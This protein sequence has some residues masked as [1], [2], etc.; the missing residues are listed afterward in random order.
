M[1][2]VNEEIKK[3]LSYCIQNDIKD[4]RITGI[5]T[6]TRVETSNDFK[7]SKVY[8]SIFDKNSKEIF[9]ILKKSIG[10]MRKSIAQNVKIR[11]TPE[12]DL[13]LDESIEYS[14]HI[15]EILKNTNKDED[16]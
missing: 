2:R 12:L 13:R 6:V 3:Q 15:N 7:S 9:E 8:L 5:I 1:E 10:K 14:F 16:A 11:F 4:T